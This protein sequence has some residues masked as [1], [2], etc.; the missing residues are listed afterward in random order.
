MG[1][2]FYKELKIFF[3]RRSNFFWLLA[4]PIVFIV[5]M[6]FVFSSINN[7]ITVHLIDRDQTTFS[8][9][10]RKQLASIPIMNVE[11]GADSEFQSQLEKIKKGTES[12][13]IVIPKGFANQFAVGKA[14]LQLYQSSD[15]NQASAAVRAVLQQLSETYREQQIKAT[16]QASGVSKQQIATTMSSPLQIVTVNQTAQKFNDVTQVVPG[17]MTMFSFFVIMTMISRF[18]QERDTGMVS[19]LQASSVRGWSYLLGMG[20]PN[21]LMVS[22]QCG[23]LLAFGHFV[24][25]MELGNIWL[26]AAL[27]LALGICGAGLGIAVSIL[28]QSDQAS[29]GV[30]QLF[31]IGGSILGGL[32]FPLDLLPAFAQYIGKITPQYWA[33][34]GFQDVMLRQ[35]TLVDII[36]SLTALIAI[37]IAGFVI[38]RMGYSSFLKRAIH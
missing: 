31:T 5:M 21:I 35:A 28:F 9:T 16:L 24:Y 38:A 20:L 36:P 4:M 25:G 2:I 23:V 32:M 1:S 13:L 11:T 8:K 12:A 27:V 15:A 14:Q 33:Q 6:N 22:L 19:R 10:F 34:H 3:K 30:T 7:E 17:Y 37:G 18:K 29:K 26:V